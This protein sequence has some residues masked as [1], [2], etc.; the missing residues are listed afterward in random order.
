MEFAAGENLD[1]GFLAK[2]IDIF[3]YI[4]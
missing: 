4:S 1:L 3:Y 2:L